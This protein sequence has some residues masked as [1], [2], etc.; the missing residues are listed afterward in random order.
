VRV[1]TDYGNL[2]GILTERRT[3]TPAKITF[4]GGN[5][6]YKNMC[7]ELE[8][9]CPEAYQGSTRLKNGRES[10]QN[11][12]CWIKPFGPSFIAT[13][14]LIQSLNLLLKDN[15]NGTRSVTGLKPGGEWV[16]KQIILCTL[17]IGVQGVIDQ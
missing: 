4:A 7:V 8:Q 16:S 12:H 10:L 17:F 3:P 13:P 11:V 5:A 1:T 6:C 14:G 9:I 15:N 2:F